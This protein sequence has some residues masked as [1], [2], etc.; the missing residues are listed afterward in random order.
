MNSAQP[1]IPLLTLTSIGWRPFVDG[2]FIPDQPQTVP[3]KVP[4]LAGSSKFQIATENVFKADASK[5]QM[6]ALYSPL[7]PTT[8][9]LTSPKPT[10][11][12]SSPSLQART[13]SK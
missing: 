12:V 3:V 8:L 9:R 10:I 2:Q 1:V 6:K 11:P 4:F 13:P 5:M 7:A